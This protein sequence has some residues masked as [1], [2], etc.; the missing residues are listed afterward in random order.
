MALKQRAYRPPPT[1]CSLPWTA[2]ETSPN[3][4]ARVCCLAND[5]ITQPNGHPYNMQEH[6]LQEA[7]QS[8]YIHNGDLLLLSSFG[9][10]FTWGSILIRWKLN[11]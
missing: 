1:I 9:A 11:D 5:L 6:S 8:D 4:E 2:V 10:G 7:F 3:G